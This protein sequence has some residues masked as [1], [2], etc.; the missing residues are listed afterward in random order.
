MR[1]CALILCS[2]AAALGVAQTRPLLATDPAKP[3]LPSESRK[4]RAATTINGR[5]FNPMVNFKFVDH[6]DDE[7]ENPMF[8]QSWLVPSEPN[9]LPVGSITEAVRGA[10]GPFWP[11]IGATGWTPADP[12]CAVGPNHV[13]VTVNEQFAFYTKAGLNVF[14]QTGP[15]FLATAGAGSNTFDPRILWDRLAN[16]WVMIWDEQN[17]TSVISNIYLCVSQTTDPT[18]GWNI[19]KVDVKEVV[20]A[21]SYW[22]DYPGFGYNKDAYIISGN[23]FSFGSGFNG[24]QF[25]VVP[26]A[27]TLVGSAFTASY[28]RDTASG[29]AQVADTADASLDRAYA[30][31]IFNASSMRVYSFT[32]VAAA[33]PTLN[34][35]NV[36]IPTFV[37]PS[38]APP[39]TPGTLSYIDSRLFE[40]AYRGGRLVM[41]H[42]ARTSADT[43]TRPRWYEIATNNYPTSAPTL[44]QSGELLGTAPAVFSM[45]AIN[46]NGYGDISAIF[47]R[48]STSIP[49]DAMA[50]G[51]K[52]TDAAGSMGTPFLLAN[53]AGTSYGGT[54]TNRW[55]DYFAVSVDPTDQA[56]FF[57]IAMVGNSGGGWQTVVNSWTITPPANL[58]SVAVSSPTVIGGNSLSGTVTLDGPAPLDGY[59]VTLSVPGGSPASVPATVTVP[60][61]ATSVGFTLNS[62]PVTSDTAVTMTAT[63]RTGTKT[64]SVTVLRPQVSGHVTL[65]DYLASPAGVPISVQIRQAGTQ[66]VLA[67]INTTL[68]A[69]GNYTVPTTVGA[70]T[71]DVAIK[72]SHWLR[73]K[74]ANVVLGTTGSV[75]VNATLTNGDVDGDNVISSADLTAVRVAFG[76][77]LAS[78][79]MNG[80]GVVG[81]ADLTIVRV[82]FGQSGD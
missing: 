38:V 15:A 52:V 31:C 78:A 23:M 81:S 8:P 63:L 17:S 21:S 75:G 1:I 64:T 61:G 45:P 36:T 2:L 11:A 62:T 37:G 66:T 12:T 20:G 40:V 3:I 54:G 53:S 42:N 9:T 55:G 35:T 28:F 51:R 18:L 49:A 57:G 44:V 22:M 67:T 13:G 60:N 33:T 26:K 43:T 74:V 73:K 68:D 47:T 72:A 10:M 80:D 58:A 71:Y 5:R 77:T 46:R 79:D 76:G 50:A 69:S 65:N 34:F 30:A 39:S 19:Y 29:G 25:V 70:G 48:S 6:D 16:R 59:A 56:T 24:V 4:V 41:S 82:N 32:N 27:P 7:H 14:S